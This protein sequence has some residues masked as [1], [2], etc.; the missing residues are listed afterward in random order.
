MNA[1]YAPQTIAVTREMNAGHA[2]KPSLLPERLTQAT[3]PNH[4]CYQR[5]EHRPRPQTIAV[6]RK[7]NTQINTYTHT[8]LHSHSNTNTTQLSKQSNFT[9]HEIAPDVRVPRLK[10]SRPEGG[11]LGSEADPPLHTITPHRHT[12]RRP[13]GAQAGGPPA[14]AVPCCRAL[15]QGS[16]AR[17][18]EAA[19][20]TQRC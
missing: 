15:G 16:P 18:T 3:P 1:G 9:F 12:L 20:Q 8:H 14:G 6:L 7:M 19:H 2:H 5:D 11:L 13:S 10:V 4:H 17:C